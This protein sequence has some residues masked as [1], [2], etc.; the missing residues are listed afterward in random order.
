MTRKL[1]VGVRAD[2]SDGSRVKEEVSI[3]TKHDVFKIPVEANIVTKEKFEEANRD[4]MIS[5]GKSI[6][7]SRVKERLVNRVKEGRASAHK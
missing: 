6:T 2:L 7:N 3:Q 4:A 5:T 1:I